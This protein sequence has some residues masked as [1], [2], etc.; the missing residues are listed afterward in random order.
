VIRADSNL[1][2][3]ALH[4]H[5]VRL[6]CET[7]FIVEPLNHLL[8]DFASVAA[9]PGTVSID[10]FIRHY[11]EKEV[12]R[13]LPGT[14]ARL[15]QP[16]ELIEVYQHDEN[17]WLIDDRWGAAEINL[18]KGQWRAW[19]VPQPNLAP[20]ACLEFA[21]LW[22]LAQ[23]LR[24]KGLS[25]VPAA[26]VVRDD[27]G[28]LLVP[29]GSIEPELTELIRAGYRVVGPRWSILREEGGRMAMLRLPGKLER[30]REPRFAPRGTRGAAEWIDLTAEFCG[31]AAEHAWCDAVI[32]ID[33]SRKPVAHIKSLAR[34]NALVTLRRAWPGLQLHS[35][36]RLSQLQA[37]LARQCKCFEARFSR[38]PQ[39]VLRLI[40][41]ARHERV[42]TSA[43]MLH[44]KSPARRVVA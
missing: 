8:G 14:A 21:A 11:D 36:R 30:S 33:R 38:Q 4:G 20:D 3:F 12:V 26:S 37:R 1:H 16:G 41:D 5:P 43:A 29:Q 42:P 24:G 39:D 7:E 13:R 22:P 10:G 44:P 9:P 15:S 25:L 35:Q 6:R 28:V 23:L 31:A 18:L 32:L 40:D 17:Y 2:L 34:T 19:I 27:W